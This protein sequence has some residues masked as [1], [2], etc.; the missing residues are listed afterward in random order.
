PGELAY[1]MQ[2]KDMFEHYQASF[3]ILVPRNSGL[4]LP[5]RPLEKFQQLGFDKKDMFRSYDELS[6]VWLSGQE[7]LQ[8]DITKTTDAVKAAYDQLAAAFAKTDPTLAASVQAEAQKVINGLDNLSKK[9][10]AAL[11]RKHEVAL[12]Q[13][14]TLLDKVNPDDEPQE[15]LVNFL[16]FYPKMGPEMIQV[17][18]QEMNPLSFE[19]TVVVE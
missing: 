4:I 6:K 14:K 8:D 1:W 10:T 18:L 13:L 5:S 7:N 16:Q 15:R 12:N 3:P 19:M 17:F 2:L 9:G 11:K